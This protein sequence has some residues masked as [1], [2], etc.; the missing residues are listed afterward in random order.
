MNERLGGLIDPFDAT[1]IKSCAYELSMGNEAYITDS[2]KLRSRMR[3]RLRSG[4]HVII[5]PGQ[6][7]QLLVKETVTIPQDSL[8]FLSMKSS[9]KMRGLVNVSGF[10]VDPGYRG[11]LVFS[12]F[13]AGSKEIMIKRNEPTFLL[14]LASLDRYTTNAYSG[15]RQGISEITSDQ[16]MNLKG[17][18][19]NPTS[20]A[21]RVSRL[22]HQHKT[23][24]Y[25]SVS[26][27][28][29]IVGGIVLSALGMAF[30]IIP[31]EVVR[32]STP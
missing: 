2:R 13:N 30:D 10:H 8:G 3:L 26:I 12:V 25:V 16:Y 17:P 27:A 21:Q 18:T 23:R 14:W 22:E 6:L 31:Y 19:Y 32:T 9:F 4:Q 7:A 28:A 15:A 1:R 20:L 5:P 29:T 24:L 11:K